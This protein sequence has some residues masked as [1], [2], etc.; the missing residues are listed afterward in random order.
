MTESQIL[1][2]IQM[3]LNWKFARPAKSFLPD[4]NLCG[5]KYCID[6]L[7]FAEILANIRKEFYIDFWGPEEEI[8][9]MRFKQSSTVRT[10]V[11]VVQEKLTTGH[12][13]LKTDLS[14]KSVPELVSIIEQQ[15]REI[16]ELKRQNVK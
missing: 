9:Y 4:T 2:K 7:D 10:L 5:Y 3:I 13:R 14:T 6:S 1:Q 16:T 12:L 11:D 8:L 15:R